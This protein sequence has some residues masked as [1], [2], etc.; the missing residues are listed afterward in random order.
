MA[1]NIFV[2]CWIWSSAPLKNTRKNS[3]RE[4]LKSPLNLAVTKGIEPSSSSVTGR[5]FIQLNYITFIWCAVKESN[6]PS[7]NDKWFTVTTASI[8]GITTHFIL[9]RL[10]TCT[11]QIGEQSLLS[12]ILAVS[13]G[14]EPCTIRLT[15]DR[16][17]L[18]CFL[19]MFNIT[20]P[21]SFK[22]FQ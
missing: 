14:F 20:R 2:A 22:F 6:L 15:A 8:Y 19:T 16:T 3:L 7:R 9:F 18:M 21:Y 12:Q 17:C 10:R 5:Y 11:L 1:W 13:Q 4:G